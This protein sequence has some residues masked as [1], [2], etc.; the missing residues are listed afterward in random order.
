MSEKKKGIR[1]ITL[2]EGKQA[3]MF[4]K[5]KSKIGL[6]TD[7]ELIRYIINDY[8]YKNMKSIRKCFRI[9]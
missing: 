4:K 2:L 7:A 5:I 9:K 8:Y 3:E 6:K 1:V